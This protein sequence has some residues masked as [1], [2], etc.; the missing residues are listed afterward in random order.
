VRPTAKGAPITEL[1]I[2]DLRRCARATLQQPGTLFDLHRSWGWTF[3]LEAITQLH[4][5]ASRVARSHPAAA[6]VSRR[7]MG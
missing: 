2:A 6:A 4:G 1:A 3:E 5:L 7:L